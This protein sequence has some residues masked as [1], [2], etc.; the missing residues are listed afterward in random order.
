MTTCQCDENCEFEISF[1][2]NLNYWEKPYCSFLWP[3]YISL[4][5]VNWV[6]LRFSSDCGNKFHYN[7]T[8]YMVIAWCVSAG[9][10][11]WSQF[12]VD[13]HL[14]YSYKRCWFISVLTIIPDDICKDFGHT[15][16]VVAHFCE[17]ISLT[18]YT[19]Y[20]I[21][22]W[23][24]EAVR[25]LVITVPADALVPNGVRPSADTGL[26]EMTFFRRS[27]LTIGFYLVVQDDVIQNGRRYLK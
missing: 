19:C 25:G 13:D 14:T 3:F 21:R 24:L 8:N 16:G 11:R 7:R 17:C 23:S 18:M 6:N 12:N 27:C 1:A 22:F 20:F 10:A 15:R 26:N 5:A 4:F 9:L 2:V